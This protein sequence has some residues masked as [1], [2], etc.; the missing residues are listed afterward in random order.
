MD[1]S[2]IVFAAWLVI[3]ATLFVIRQKREVANNLTV[4]KLV[5]QDL[6][7]WEKI[8]ING[9]IK[10]SI[11]FPW[12]FLTY[13]MARNTFGSSDG[14]WSLFALGTGG[15]VLIWIFEINQ[16]LYSREVENQTATL[17]RLKDVH[18]TT[19]VFWLGLIVSYLFFHP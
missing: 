11:A 6:R 13:F 3:L 14:F 2:G 10:H 17:A 8:K 4:L 7:S 19:G 18:F 1:L 12:G 16:G 5:F 15:W 9:W